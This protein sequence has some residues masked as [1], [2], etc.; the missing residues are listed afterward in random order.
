M[1]SCQKPFLGCP[2]YFPPQKIHIHPRTRDFLR[3]RVCGFSN[4]RLQENVVN[5]VNLFGGAIFMFPPFNPPNPVSSRS[6]KQA[7]EPKN[8][9]TPKITCTCF[10]CNRHTKKHA[11]P[12]DRQKW[13]NGYH[14]TS[15]P[16]TDF[17]HY[18][19]KNH[20]RKISIKPKYASVPRSQSR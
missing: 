10:L 7:L 19:A 1:E 3:K 15:S 6:A 16:T 17:H 11:T 13:P 8:T 20:V 9:C 5:H 18:L 2:H 12:D 4:W 14:T